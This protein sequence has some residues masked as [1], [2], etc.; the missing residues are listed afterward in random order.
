MAVAGGHAP[1]PRGGTRAWTARHP[2]LAFF[3]LAYAWSWACWAPLL[4]GAGGTLVLGGFGPFL[5][6]AAVTWLAGEPLRPWARAIVR[7]RV[8]A[9]WWAWAL[10]LPALLYAV[11]NLV[12]GALGREIDW[13]LALGR[14]PAYL[15]TFAFV[16]VLGGGLE[17][18]GWRGFALP[19]LQQRLGP[20]RATALLGLLWGVWHVPLYGPLGFVVPLVLAVFYT[21]LRN[22]T[23]SVLLCV[24]LHASFTPAQD[25]LVL[26]AAEP[27][28]TGLLD[29]VD[30]VVLGTYAG[31][32]LLVVVLTRGRLGAPR[33]R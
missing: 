26:L 20:L 29:V 10:G 19:R 28:H 7:W 25:H 16:A 4:A 5:A 17:E 13:S 11:V 15:A 24:L 33:P 2:L 14:A 8:P 6:A 1:A 12:L 31:A 21:P 9:R 3:L 27:V 18:P 32:A 23:G 30:L 22:R